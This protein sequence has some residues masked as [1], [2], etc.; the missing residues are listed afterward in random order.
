VLFVQIA[1]VIAYLC[2]RTVV[3]VEPGYVVTPVCMVQAAYVLMAEREKLPPGY[4]VIERSSRFIL[5]T[6]QH[7]LYRQLSFSLTSPVLGRGTP[8]LPCP[9][10]SSSFPLFTFSFLSLAL[11]IS[12]F[13]PSLPFLPE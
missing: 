12:F 11:P 4:V 5:D 8:L 1:I 3:T 7:S 6:V 9:F 10:T 2:W 13:C